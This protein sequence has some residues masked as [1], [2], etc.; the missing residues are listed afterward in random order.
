MN[1]L[2]SERLPW[3]AGFTASIANA[4]A[5]KNISFEELARRIREFGVLTHAHSV[6]EIESGARSITLSE[7]LVIC[8]VLDLGLPDI[9]LPVRAELVNQSFA[10]DI[11]NAET[12]WGKVV[13]RLAQVH[14]DV[15]QTLQHLLYLRSSYVEAIDSA[16]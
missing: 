10:E 9:L 3:E 1:Q 12:D 2:K 11:D 7:A 4:R 5:S 13:E 15:M 14:R 8:K 6:E 16:G